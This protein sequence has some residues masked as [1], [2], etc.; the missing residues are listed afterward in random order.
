MTTLLIFQLF[1][2]KITEESR[3]EK[4]QVI[5]KERL[6]RFNPELSSSQLLS[7]HLRPFDS[8]ANKP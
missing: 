8:T 3:E 7:C 4:Q 1:I 2:G 6:A 5:S